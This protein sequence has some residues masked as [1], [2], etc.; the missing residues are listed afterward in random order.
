MKNRSKRSL[1]A[2]IAVFIS[3]TFACRKNDLSENAED[4]LRSQ[5]TQTVL[6]QKEEILGWID[7]HQYS[8]PIKTGNVQFI[9]N[10]LVYENLHVE[11]R[12]NGEDL[13][14]IPLNRAVNQKLKLANDYLLNLLVVKG[15]NGKLRWSMVVAFMPEGGKKTNKLRDRTLQQII[16]NEPVQDNGLYKFFDLKGKLLYQLEY[17]DNR[18]ASYASPRKKGDVAGADPMARGTLRCYAYYLVT[19]YFRE[20]GTIFLQTSEYLYTE[21]DDEVTD[22]PDGGGSGGIGGDS[23]DPDDPIDATLSTVLVSSVNEQS[24]DHDD[25]QITEDME[26]EYDADNNPLPAYGVPTPLLYTCRVRLVYYAV[27]RSIAELEA[28]PVTVEPSDIT[29]THPTWGTVVRVVSLVDKDE[30]TFITSAIS[31]TA[32]W[33]CEVNYRWAYVNGSSRTRQ[34]P[35]RY[36]APMTV[37]L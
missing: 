16:N 22:D 7:D 12:K 32:W 36:V 25:L 26:T 34:I 17:K 10:N 14:V 20:D 19:T 28:L 35:F 5:K 24:W 33:R 2:L 37:P 8:S 15:N 23:G 6:A 13:I 3:L 30:G 18:L 1:L 31:F 9:K 4:L 21:C 29:Y 27:S 11:K